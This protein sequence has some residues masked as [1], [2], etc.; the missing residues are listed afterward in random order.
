MWRKGGWMGRVVKLLCTLQNFL[1]Q[2]N[3]K[4][5]Y[6]VSSWERIGL[7]E[8]FPTHSQPSQLSQLRREVLN[9]CHYLLFVKICVFPPEGSGAPCVANTTPPPPTWPGTGKEHGRYSGSCTDFWALRRRGADP[10]SRRKPVSVNP[11][12]W[13]LHWNVK[14]T[15][16]RPEGVGGPLTEFDSEESPLSKVQ[17]ATTRKQTEMVGFRL[18]KRTMQGVYNDVERPRLPCCRW[19]EPPRRSKS[20]PSRWLGTTRDR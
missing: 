3:S 15:H 6:E 11:L 1:F 8:F 2:N 18:Q 13:G 17:A 10:F 4:T 5:W 14:P 12:D 19:D 9:Y 7:R 20:K 16:Q